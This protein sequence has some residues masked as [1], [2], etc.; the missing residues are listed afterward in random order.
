MGLREKN[1]DAQEAHKDALADFKAVSRLAILAKLSEAAPGSPL[2][3]SAL[4]VSTARGPSPGCDVSRVD[5]CVTRARAHVHMWAFGLG[6]REN[7][8]CNCIQ[9]Q[10]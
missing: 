8:E 2:T 10:F 4:P 3:V 6:G 1:A 5:A 9:W 7:G